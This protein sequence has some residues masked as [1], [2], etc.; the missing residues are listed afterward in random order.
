MSTAIENILCG[1]RLK[2]SK[3]VRTNDPREYADWDFGPFLDGDEHSGE[4]FAAQWPEATSKLNQVRRDYR[5]ACFCSND[6]PELQKTNSRLDER[7]RQFGYNRLRMW[8]Q[9]GESFYGVCIAFS[10]SSLEQWL[11][12]GSGVDG[13][14]DTG[15]VT[16]DRELYFND[17]PILSPDGSEFMDRDK[18]TYA[19]EFIRHNLRRLFF[20]KHVDYKDEYEYR[21]VV[22][23]PND[24][25]EYVDI[26]SSIRAVLL[27]DRSKAVYRR[28]VR[29]LCDELH[30]PCWEL[31]WVD[32]ELQLRAIDWSTREKGSEHM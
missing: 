6:H 23:D 13:L 22:H 27:G 14:V 11:R 30:V 29:D 5:F 20:T 21:I 25:C 12:T 10:S 7:L 8:A 16:Y 31:K 4:E 24:D 1:R 9:Y 28:I 18:V 17:R 15:H 32:G 26:V 2:L 19:N 3:D